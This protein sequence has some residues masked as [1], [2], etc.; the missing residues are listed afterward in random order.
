MQ[1]LYFY[2]L[3]PD[4]GEELRYSIRS[5]V[6]NFQGEARIT[7]IGERPNWYNGHFI[8]LPSKKRRN[9]RDA[10]LDTQRKVVVASTHH[11]IDDEFAWIMDDVYILQPVTIE[12]LKQPRVDPWYRVK[13]NKLWHR[14]I[15]NTFA[16]LKANG[17][18]NHQ[19]ATHLP[20]HFE[21]QKLVELFRHYDYPKNLYIFENLYGN[22]F[23]IDPCPY[24]A[25]WEGVQ[26]PQ[27]LR[28]ILSRPRRISEIEAATSGAFVLNYQASVYSKF[29][30]Q[31][32]ESKFPTKTEFES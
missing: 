12:D 1:F 5:V 27:F 20:H 22:H 32:L 6:Q 19:Y 24:G 18:P 11:E 15:A 29:M 4:N 26:Y 8:P 13:S 16:A 28:R 10:F 21:K 14:L 7:I 31:F 17:K 2:I 30:K 25:T 9:E 23:R 3:G